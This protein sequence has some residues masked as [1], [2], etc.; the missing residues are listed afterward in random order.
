MSDGGFLGQLRQSEPDPSSSRLAS[1]LSIYSQV[2]R[3]F[4]INLHSSTADT[5]KFRDIFV[6]DVIRLSDTRPQKYEFCGFLR[7]L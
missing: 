1:A 7:H 2:Q 6:S 4:E 5:F 3:Q